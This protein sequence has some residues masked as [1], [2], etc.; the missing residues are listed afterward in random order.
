M[1]DTTEARHQPFALCLALFIR[2]QM[3]AYPVVQLFFVHC[4]G[5]ESNKGIGEFSGL[6]L[7]IIPIPFENQLDHQGTDPLVAIQK[8]V[9]GC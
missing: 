6:K 9:V 8:S 5:C 2:F 4:T 7:E 3:L 1:F